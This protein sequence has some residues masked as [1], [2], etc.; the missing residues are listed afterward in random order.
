MRPQDRVIEGMF[1]IAN[2][3]AITVD[4][5]LNPV[6]KRFS[7]EMTSRDIILKARREGFS[8][9]I[10][11]LFLVACLTEPNTR[12][13]ILSQDT[14]ATQKHLAEVKYYI[15]H[16]K[17]P[18]PIIGYDSKNFLSFPKT[19]SS[20]Y[21]G[22][23]GDKDFGRGDTI[24][25]LLLSE[26][27]FYPDLKALIGSVMQAASFAKHIV[28]EST[29]NGF[30]H[31]QKM[32]ER[33]RH[34]DGTFKLH[35]Y[36]WFEDADNFLPLMKGEKLFLNEEDKERMQTYKLTREQ[37]K[38]YIAKREEFMEGPDDVEGRNMFLQEYPSSIEE[39]FIASGAKFFRQVPFV[40]MKPKEEAGNLIVYVSPRPDHRYTIGIDYSGGLGLDPTVIQVLDTDTFEQVAIYRDAWTT[41]DRASEIAAELGRK[42]N[43]AFIIPEL[44]NHG[45]LGVDVLKRIYPIGL[46]YRR[47]VPNRKELEKRNKTLGFVTTE[48]GKT[49]LCN[50][51]KLYLRRGLVIHNSQ[52]EH[53]LLTFESDGGKLGAPT[54][55]FDDCVIALGLAAIGMK[56]LIAHEENMNE[57]DE[58]F[59]LIDVE[60]PIYP[61]DNIDDLSDIIDG[62]R[63]GWYLL[64]SFYGDS[65]ARKL[66]RSMM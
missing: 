3:Q 62:N 39:A 40:A 23:A 11:A 18:Q 13:V 66:L 60:K 65:Y 50:T 22:T 33:A 49:Y 55:E 31:F 21:I 32:C 7:D 63:R 45:Q 12:A 61:F 10:R 59:E 19:D 53:E 47:Q 2:K 42:Y 34:G 54:G 15:K 27:A 14:E 4:F 48:T 52:T 17:G 37:M 58:A 46:I 56:Q 8:S 30:N 64:R 24:T 36:A 6:Q 25:H 9:Y 26:A 16:L 1:R 20:Y 5:K 28:I 44:N 51:L 35:F 57:D 38:W 29:A 43:N 41:P